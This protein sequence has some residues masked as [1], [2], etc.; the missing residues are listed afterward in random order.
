MPLLWRYLLRSYFQI[1]LLCV[2]GFI[3]I[4]LV[5]RVQEIAR[6]ASLNSH[7][8]KICLFTLFQIPYI[9]PIAIP[10]AGLIAAILLFQ[11]LSHTQEL[12]AFRVFGIKI[13]TLTTPLLM[14]AFLLSLLNF[15]IVTEITPRC[16]Y[17]S[18]KL[19]QNITL[20][21]P[22]FLMKKSKILKLQDC[23]V[24][25][26]MT[27]LGKEAEEIIFAVKNESNDRLSL[28]TAKKF[29]VDNNLMTGKNVAI[30]SNIG[31]DGAF[32]DNLII[33]NQETMSTS[34]SAL[35]SLMQRTTQHIGMKYLPMKTL[36]KT[37][38]DPDVKAK[39]VKQAKFEVCRRIFF[40][41][42]TFAFTLLGFS[43]G[44][45]IGRGRKK[46]GIYIAILLSSL[47][48]ICSIAAK[49]FQLVPYKVVFFYT[50]PLPIL[51]FASYWFQRRIIGGVE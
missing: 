41:V 2:K 38:S 17:Y 27:H 50:L 40:P 44:M 23:Y 33:E 18:N 16:R 7:F 26:K 42:I 10:I 3:A 21:N 4:L 39:T 12:T 32:Y 37:F 11:R 9:L 48:F 34:A 46:R 36:L 25:M 20:I 47:T 43:L 1:F 8:G 49:S 45:Q 31:D 24:D 13:Q 15:A 19:I 51:F 6:L 35:S 5:T 22:L 29:T 28:M 30:I 14:A